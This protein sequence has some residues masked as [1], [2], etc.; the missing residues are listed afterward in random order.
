[1]SKKSKRVNI[2]Q[3]SLDR[4]RREASGEIVIARPPVAAKASESKRTTPMEAV[5]KTSPEDL[6]AEYT[7][8][9]SDLRSMGLLAASLFGGLIVLAILFS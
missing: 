4:A 6:A 5:R 7:Y 1:M 2:S 8:V 3:E 9:I